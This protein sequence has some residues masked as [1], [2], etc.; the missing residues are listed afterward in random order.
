MPARP[1]STSTP[2]L[3]PPPGRTAAKPRPPPSS[4]L[5]RRD[6]RRSSRQ[7]ETQGQRPHSSTRR[8]TRATP[9]CSQPGRPTSS[10]SPAGHRW[11]TSRRSARPWTTH[12]SQARPHSSRS[13]RRLSVPRSSPRRERRSPP[14]ASRAHRWSSTT[15]STTCEPSPKGLGGWRKLTSHVQGFHSRKWCACMSIQNIMLNLM[16]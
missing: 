14:T 2:K 12:G 15:D 13:T 7:R 16:R 10:S 1:S 6:S 4:V 8:R 9:N 3:R 11:Q 5:R